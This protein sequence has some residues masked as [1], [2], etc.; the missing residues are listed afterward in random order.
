MIKET[1]DFLNAALEEEYESVYRLFADFDVPATQEMIDH[2]TIQVHHEHKLRMIGIL[3][4]FFSDNQRIIMV[5]ND[6]NHI[7]RF[8][9]GEVN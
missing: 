7:L 9:V 6:K 8:E 5:Q 1:V 4:G 2:P 3:N